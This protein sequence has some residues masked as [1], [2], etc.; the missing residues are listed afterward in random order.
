MADIDIR[1][2]PP[3]LWPW[4]LALGIAVVAILWI[5]GASNDR[6]RMGGD[7]TALNTNTTASESSETQGEPMGTT[8]IVPAPIRDYALFVGDAGGAGGGTPQTP[9][10]EYTAE[11]LRKLSTALGSLGHEAG[12]DD[13]PR[14]LEVIRNAADQIVQDPTSLRHAELVR[15]AFMDAVAVLDDVEAA[16]TTSLR[17]IAESMREDRPLLEQQETVREFF[18]QSA[19]AI[20]Q[21]AS[22]E[23]AS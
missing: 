4:L 15:E 7:T 5:W 3:A 19:D 16:S 10:H 1:R 6:T 17:T 12:S 22:R 20:E 21:A 18:R 2:K 14:R 9:A 11:G 8:G 13:T 23:R